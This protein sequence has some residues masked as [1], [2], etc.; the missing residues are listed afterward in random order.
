M[1]GLGF[2]GMDNSNVSDVT[3]NSLDV[4]DN[5][6]ISR[7]SSQLPIH[8]GMF[9]HLAMGL[10]DMGRSTHRYVDYIQTSRLGFGWWHVVQN[11]FDYTQYIL[12]S[13]MAPQTCR[14]VQAH[15]LYDV[16]GTS[17]VIYTASIVENANI[18]SSN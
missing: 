9:R 4:T 11:V 10:T 8:A 14:N 7:A 6:D 1:F 2:P 3:A 16:H 17:K 18:F 15:C 13:N 5:I 12:C